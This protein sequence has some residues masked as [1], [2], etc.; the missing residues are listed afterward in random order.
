MSGLT[1]ESINPVEYAW[2]F[3]NRSVKLISDLHLLHDLTSLSIKIFKLVYEEILKPLKL[4]NTLNKRH[5]FMYYLD[6]SK[7]LYPVKNLAY[8]MNIITQSYY[9][10]L[11]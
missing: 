6:I 1:A 2:S 8:F 10:T 5:Y 7:V 9:L 4:M 3:S 11:Q